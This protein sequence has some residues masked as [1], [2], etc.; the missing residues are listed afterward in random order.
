MGFAQAL[1][2][3]NGS[4]KNL[5]VIG[6]NI[7]NS[8]T[9]GFKSQSTQFAD[10]YAGSKVGQGVQVAGIQQN[11]NNGNLETTGRGLDL[12]ISGG[13]FFTFLQANGTVG[14]SRN[15]QVTRNVNGNLENAQGALLMG[16]SGPIQV[17]TASMPSKA[18]TSVSSVVNL[19]AGSD[20]ITLPFDPTN[21]D[22]YSF[23]TV[24]NTYDSLGNMQTV[25]MNYVK[26]G[27]NQWE[28][29]A[30]M[31]GV[32]SASGPQALN[33]TTNGTL[34]GYT[35]SNFQFAMTNGAANL[36]F[37]FDATGTTQ[38][39][40][41]F[42][43]SSTK[44]DGYTNGDLVGISVDKSG[45]VVGNYSNQQTLILGTLQL[46]NFLNPEGLNPIGNNMFAAT[47]ESGQA[48]LGTAGVGQ[49]GTV[50]S[51]MLEASNVDL[52]GELVKL[53]VA[54]RTYQANSSVVK[55]NDEV[56]QQAVNLR[57]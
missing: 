13:G 25:N 6:N 47:N 22:T 2:G 38:F 44:Q 15:G 42:Y 20:I 7:A 39:G 49:F 23:S 10:M 55:T 41:D 29:Y 40:S 50:Q 16:A 48:L 19:D 4:A 12:A 9:Y 30:S 46:A 18:T 11:F 33:F 8:Q 36:D 56:L 57:N 32:A 27:V 14:Y 1:S 5:D 21:P 52:T 26:T 45:N 3:L 35:P 43:N 53:I 17:S 24:V 31:N 34:T 37:S 54:Q 51:G 28:V